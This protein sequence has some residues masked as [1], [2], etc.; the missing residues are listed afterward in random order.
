MR[1]VKEKG[2]NKCELKENK[3][4]KGNVNNRIEN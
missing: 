3:K 1:N 4:R 2:N